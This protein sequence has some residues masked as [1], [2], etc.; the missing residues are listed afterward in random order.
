MQTREDVEVLNTVANKGGINMDKSV[1]IYKY[2]LDLLSAKDDGA[3]FVTVPVD[4]SLLS[5]IQQGDDLVLY[6]QVPLKSIQNSQFETRK[7]YIYGTGIE[8]S[9]ITDEG[10][11]LIHLGTVSMF[12]GD[13]ILHVFWPAKP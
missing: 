3:L 10:E 2:S 4:S 8:Y 1:V 6:C 12:N 13:L 11:R 7:L 5:V 9:P